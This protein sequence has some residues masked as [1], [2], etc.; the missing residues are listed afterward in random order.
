MGAY[1]FW[2][3]P[4]SWETD[5]NPLSKQPARSSSSLKKQSGRAMMRVGGLAWRCRTIGFVIGME[6]CRLA[7]GLAPLKVG[8]YR[9]W[10]GEVGDEKRK[11]DDVVQLLPNAT[12]CM[13]DTAR[14]LE[15]QRPL[16]SMSRIRSMC[17]NARRGKERKKAI[18]R[19]LSP[20]GPRSMSETSNLWARR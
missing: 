2:I 8:A 19:I 15:S 9:S 5:A 7:A 17:G 20:H 14:G 12:Q 10:D 13:A 18:I 1:R 11:K 4:S 6:D 16:E 3:G